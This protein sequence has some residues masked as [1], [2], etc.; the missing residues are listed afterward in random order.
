[1]ITDKKAWLDFAKN[2]YDHELLVEDNMQWSDKEYK[3]QLEIAKEEY[4]TKL[5]NVLT[6]NNRKFKM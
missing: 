2:Y 5:E 3:K 4:K 1:M 6:E